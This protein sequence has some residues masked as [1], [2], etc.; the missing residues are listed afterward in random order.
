LENIFFKTA[1]RVFGFG[2]G[3]RTDQ[4]TGRATAASWSSR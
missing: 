2:N 1:T 3:V 4:Q